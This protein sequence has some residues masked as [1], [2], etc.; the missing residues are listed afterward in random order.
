MFLADSV[1]GINSIDYIDE[2]KNTTLEY[3]NKMNR[4]YPNFP[5]GENPPY[6]SLKWFFS[7]NGKTPEK[8]AYLKLLRKLDGDD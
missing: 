8:L 2:V 1:R 4:G 7:I 3:I 5:K 6:L